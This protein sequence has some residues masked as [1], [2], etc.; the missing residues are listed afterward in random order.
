MT[1]PTT[2]TQPVP[3]RGR[4]PQDHLPKKETT[5]VEERRYTF[6]WDGQTYNLPPAQT[7]V[8]QIP[9]KRLRDAYMDDNEGQMRLGFAMLEVVDADPGALDAL[10]SMPAPTM[11]EH[12]QNWMEVSAGETA[13]TMG[14]SS[15]S[16]S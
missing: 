12:I 15:R 7:A 13:A 4:Q 16:S 1:G 3:F 14:E 6:E 5:P 8:G 10:Y 11:L 2:V 9:G